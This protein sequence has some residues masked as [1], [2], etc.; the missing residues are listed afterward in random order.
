MPLSQPSR[1]DCPQGLAPRGPVDKPWCERPIAGPPSWTEG[2]ESAFEKSINQKAKNAAPR[3][4]RR[5]AAVS[6]WPVLGIG[7][8]NEL[9]RT[10]QWPWEGYRPNDA[11]PETLRSASRAARRQGRGVQS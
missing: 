11:G 2:E 10:G 7:V 4:F 9:R 1:L 8:E 6:R 5:L 3:G